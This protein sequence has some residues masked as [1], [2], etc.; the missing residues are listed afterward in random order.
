LSTF[1]LKASGECGYNL[2]EWEKVEGAVWY[3]IYRGEGEGNEESMPLTDFPIKETTYKDTK[4]LKE[5]V[6]YCYYV[7]A[8]D[9]KNVETARSIEA[10]AI[11]TC[12]SEPPEDECE[13]NLQFKIGNIYYW[14]NGEQ[15]GPMLTAPILRWDRTFLI[16]RHVIEEV[17]G[18]IFWDGTNKIVTIITKEGKKIEF[19]IGN[20]MYK[21]NGVSKQIDPYNPNVVP[22]IDNGRTLIPLRVTGEELNAKEINWYADRMIAEL[23]FPCPERI[24]GR[25]VINV[26]TNCIK[27][28]TINIYD[29]AGNLVA[30]GSPN[31]NGIFDTDC[32]LPCPATYKVVPKNENCKFYPESQEVKVPCCPDVAKVAFKCDCEEEVKKICA[33]LVR[34]TIQPDNNGY[35]QVN[36]KENCES[37]D[38]IFTHVLNFPADLLDRNL[39]INV[40]DYYNQFEHPVPNGLGCIS[41]VFNPS[42]NVVSEWWAYPDR[43]PCCGESCEWICGC[44]LKAEP[45]DANYW[46][47]VFDKGCDSIDPIDL[48]I[49][50]DLHDINFNLVIE[51][52]IKKFPNN[53][54]W[55]VE[56]CL[57]ESGKIVNWKATPEKYPDCCEKEGG[58]IIVSMPKECLE[59]TTVYIYS[60]DG[61]EVWHGAANNQGVFDT[62]ENPCILKCPATYKVVPKNERCKFS[63]ESAEVRV[64][65][66]PDYAKVEFKCE[67]EEEV[68]KGGIIAKVYC[69]QATALV[70]VSGVKINIF[71]TSD[72]TLIWTGIT[73]STGKIDTC[74]NIEPGQYKVV[75]DD[76]SNMCSDIVP[77]SHIANVIAGNKVE[78][79]FK[80]KCLG[81]NGRIIVKMSKECLAG[82]KVIIYDK[83][84][85]EVWSG[86]A[87]SDGVFD[88]GCTLLCPGGPYK[89][90]PVNDKCKFSPPAH[91]VRINKC[92]PEYQEVAFK[93][94]CE[95]Q[96]KK[97][98]IDVIIPDN[99]MKETVIEIYDANG[100]LITTI[101]EPTNNVFT[102]GCTLPCPGVYLVKPINKNCKFSPES[103]KVELKNCCPDYA[104]IEFKCECYGRIS[105]TVPVNCIK[106]TTIIIYDM[107]GNIVARGEPNANGIFDTDCKLPCPATYKVV[108]KNEN[109]KFYPESQEVKVPCCPDVAKV[110]FKCECEEVK[111]GKIVVTIPGNCVKGTTIYIYDLA[112]KI[113]TSGSPNANGVF[114]TD[115]KL[116]CPAT[117]KVVPKNENCKFYPESQEVKVPCCPDYAKVEFKCECEEVKYGKIVVTIPGNCVKGTT[118]YIY[119]LAGKI[120]TSGSPNANGVFDTDCKLPCPATYKVVPKNENCKFYPESQEVKVPCCPDYAKVEFKCECENKGTTEPFLFFKK[121]R[122]Y[123]LKLLN[124]AL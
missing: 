124:V 60:M 62:G 120:V 115:C 4:G 94:E 36:I 108:P 47:I 56:L 53:K 67:C 99:C 98:R 19:Q 107:K 31:L 35:Y 54:Y 8:L 15:K 86:E 13:L 81:K 28:T 89:V 65:C 23:I 93:C 119:D 45:A 96:V 48:Q 26:S 34:M 17:G 52:Y 49:P 70:P 76:F 122:S 50:A 106:G 21:V 121:I 59:G 11:P 37:G 105:V 82:T 77:P 73:D 29:A 72:G 30:L 112:G 64:P 83:D 3:Y 88:T 41:V 46:I 118:I 80:C 25:I 55:C 90:V 79:G 20:K 69:D 2:L 85:I 40:L 44:I 33:C 109:C 7:R 111:Y 123:I 6:K 57:D 78:L 43:K 39:G 12:S 91:E 97:G 92:C 38:P 103:Q 32:K 16:I 1:I 117:Y 116:P 87:N 113:V 75:P 66:C 14:V 42:N 10:C 74:F 61:V 27:G 84:G 104:R 101:K 68:K 110:E 22:F 24:K 9:E 51:D 114:D 102:T 63:P 95:E 100:R 58:R 18:E 71:R 5:G